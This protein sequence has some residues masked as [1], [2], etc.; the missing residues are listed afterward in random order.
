LEDVIGHRGSLSSFSWPSKLGVIVHACRQQGSTLSH[1]INFRWSSSL[2]RLEAGAEM[3]RVCQKS[4]KSI[5]NRNRNE[6]P[7]SP[8]LTYFIFPISLDPNQ[9]EFRTQGNYCSPKKPH[10][11]STPKQTP[12]HIPSTPPIIHRIKR[13]VLSH[14][15]T[16]ILAHLR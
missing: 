3:A 13:V 11:E 16:I 6:I 15:S 10:L 2:R 12:P 5:G 1:I 9:P 14:A 4:P 8:P 7:Q